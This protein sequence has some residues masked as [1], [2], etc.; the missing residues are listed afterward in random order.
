MESDVREFI[1]RC[2]ICQMCT[3]KL[4]KGIIVHHIKSSKPL[5]RFQIDLVTLASMIASKKH[6][7]LFT[8]VDHFSNFGW[9]RCISD[10]TS[11]TVIKALK[12][13][14]ATHHKPQMIQ[15]DN[16]SEFTSRE[17]KNFL[18]EQN[19]EQKFGP[20]Y[21]PS[22]KVQLKASTKLFKNSWRWHDTSR[23]L[24]LIWI[25]QWAIFY[26]IIT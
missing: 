5:E 13:C 15:S 21:R 1:Y 17:F 20:P 10:N 11:H 7:Y 9:L 3:G 6:K 26:T 23:S 25:N 2:H 8:M 19:I 4:R 22:Q 14:L 24:N 16:G 18:I 12:S